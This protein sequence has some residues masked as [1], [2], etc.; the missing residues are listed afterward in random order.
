MLQEAEGV[1]PAAVLIGADS[2][3]DLIHPEVPNSIGGFSLS[4]ATVEPEGLVIFDK[5]GAFFDDAGFAY[6]PDGKFPPGNGS[7]ESPRFRSLGGG[8]YAFTSS[9]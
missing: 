4:R 8:W 6:L 7:F 1:D 2:G 9:W 5:E 3:Y